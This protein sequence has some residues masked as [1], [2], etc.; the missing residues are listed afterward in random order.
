MKMLIADDDPVWRRMIE[1]MVKQWGDEPVVVADGDQ[2]WSA[3]QGDDR[4]SMAIL[5]WLM[6]GLDGLEICRRLRETA[7]SPYVYVLLLT[8]KDSKTDLV[9][10]FEAGA[11]DF[12]KKPF[13]PEELR[14]RLRAATRMLDLQAALLKAQDDLRILATRDGLTG[15]FNRRAILDM[16]EREL[17]RTQREGSCLAVFVADVD[18]FKVVNDTYGH[19]AGDAV[20]RQVSERMLASVRAYDSVGRYGGEELLLVLP[21]C[22]EAEAL[23]TAERTRASIEAAPCR[24][25]EQEIP[26]RVSIGISTSRTLGVFDAKALIHAADAALYRAKNGGRNRCEAATP[27][28]LTR[29]TV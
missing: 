14:A 12:I 1:A 21:H 13:D 4:P 10:A 16:L 18:H 26:V 11:D 28:D 23:R 27:A 15:L 20:L 24:D 17:A 29:A 9:Q 2:A 22:E 6:P 5:D 7:A 25:G 8:A 3:L 19:G